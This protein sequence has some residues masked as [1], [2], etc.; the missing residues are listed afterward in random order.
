M[1]GKYIKVMAENQRMNKNE[2]KGIQTLTSLLFLYTILKAL[3]FTE[4]C[5]TISGALIL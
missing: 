5:L 2:R 4:N 3:P 1:K